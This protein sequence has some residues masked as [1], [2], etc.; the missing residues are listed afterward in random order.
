MVKCPPTMWETWVQSLGREDPLEKEMAIH[1]S[2]LTWKIP[3]M[4]ERGRLQSMVSQTVRHDWVTSLH[5]KVLH[6]YDSKSGKLS[7][8]HRTGKGQFSFHPK[9]GQCQRMFKL[10][11]NCT[12]FTR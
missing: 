7:N 2:M 12:H 5:F 4:E 6:S 8:C 10:P 9:E 11:H 1:S 3:W